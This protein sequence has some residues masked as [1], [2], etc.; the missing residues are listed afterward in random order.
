MTADG[1]PTD[2]DHFRRAVRLAPDDPEAQGDLGAALGNR[3]EIDAAIHHLELALNL[4]PETRGPNYSLARIEAH[5]GQ[6]DRAIEHLQR[7]LELRPDYDP[8]RRLL[9]AILADRDR[10]SRDIKQLRHLIDQHPADML[11]LTNA[12]WILSTNPNASLRNGPAAVKYG[13]RAAKITGQ[14]DPRALDVLAAAYAEVGRF[15][16]ASL[17]EKRALELT[18]D[19]VMTK[20]LRARLALYQAQKPYRDIRAH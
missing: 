5:R 7:E 3:G 17:A 1:N 6:I 9:D 4:N 16:D 10:A 13:E 12:S 20:Q 2:I 19:E 14:D 15:S 8:A 18:T 11:L